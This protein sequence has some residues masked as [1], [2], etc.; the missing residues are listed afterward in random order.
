[1][2]V[3]AMNEEYRQVRVHQ[4]AMLR[5]AERSRETRRASELSRAARRAERADQ[6]LASRWQHA[7]RLHD[8]LAELQLDPQA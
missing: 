8:R 4:Q 6:Q 2:A 1:M 5:A 7:A 3:G